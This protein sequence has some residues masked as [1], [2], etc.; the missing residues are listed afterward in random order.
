MP[1]FPGNDENIKPS[2]KQLREQ[3]SQIGHWLA[4]NFTKSTPGQAV[5]TSISHRQ[6]WV[7]CLAAPQTEPVGLDLETLQERDAP[8]LLEMLLTDEERKLLIEDQQ[9]PLFNFYRCWTLKEALGKQTRLGW[10]APK[11]RLDLSLTQQ[12]C[13]NLWLPELQLMLAYALSP[14]SATPELNRMLADG[15]TQPLAHVHLPWHV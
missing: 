10:D 7:A 13:G 2:R 8:A 5:A 6:H 14:G 11:E 3:Q 1:A 15:S 12:R 9:N 4:E